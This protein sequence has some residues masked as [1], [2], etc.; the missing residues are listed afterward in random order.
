[1]IH[2]TT[3]F[4]VILLLSIFVVGGIILYFI[5]KAGPTVTI[6][7][8]QNI[9]PTHYGLPEPPAPFTIPSVT[10]TT[11]NILTRN[12][13]SDLQWAGDIWDTMTGNPIGTTGANPCWVDAA[14]LTGLTN[15]TQTDANNLCTRPCAYYEPTQLVLPN[16]LCDCYPV[17]ETPT[18]I[19][20][21][22][23]TQSAPV[24]PPVAINY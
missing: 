17:L 11:N 21:A 12:G 16:G 24:V 6:P 20:T 15:I 10:W 13:R 14:W 23:T 4:V 18:A 5:N 22:I 7:V 2:F 3:T 8:P 9:Y 19:T 1:M